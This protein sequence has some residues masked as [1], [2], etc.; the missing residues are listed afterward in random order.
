M[1]IHG[2]LTR[3]TSPEL[4]AKIQPLRPKNACE[5]GPAP[6]EARKLAL[7]V[8]GKSLG[9]EFNGIT[10]AIRTLL[11][12]SSETGGDPVPAVLDKLKGALDK[13]GEALK[14]AGFS[15]GQVDKALDDVRAQ[16]GASFA[17]SAEQTTAQSTVYGRK[18]TASLSI[19]TQ[20]G[21]QVRVRF[22]TRNG[23]AAGDTANASDSERRVYG[24][25]SGRIEISVQGEL[26]E[27]ER[28]AIGELVGKVETLA[29]DFFAGDIEKAFAA[30]AR[31]GFDGEQIASFAL[32]LSTK[33]ILRNGNPAI[34]ADKPPAL[35]PVVTKP[36]KK[37]TS[38]TTFEPAKPV[39]AAVS[40]PA[41]SP[42]AT[43]VSAPSSAVPVAA[44]PSPVPPS[45]EVAPTPT[46]D[47]VPL[48]LATTIGHFFRQV[49]DLMSQPMSS[50]RFEFSMQWKMQ[51]V[52]DAVQAAKPAT[53]PD[54]GT[55]L[56]TTTLTALGEQLAAD[57]AADIAA[58][59]DPE[60]G[61]KASL[62]PALDA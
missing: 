16:L 12:R 57:A 62:T 46:A 30:A 18:D 41:T 13:A 7:Q 48:Q 50:G 26:N 21:D 3:E 25:A 31:L 14:S 49:F 24:F 20:E 11:V 45:T 42:A 6:A 22:A 15:E 32:K 33:E 39:A 47:A 4:M 52:V 56:L 10:Q 5:C 40:K 44:T 34:A 59:E 61:T 23:F 55:Q 9:M 53:K 27:E 29:K 19:E 43:P 58:K 1:R 37:P 8:V 51:L 54:T 2:G 28:A 35:P 36:L 17:A 60:A 38:V